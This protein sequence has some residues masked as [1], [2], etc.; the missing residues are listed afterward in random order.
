MSVFM[1]EL[2]GTAFILLFGSG[3]VAGVVLEKTKSNNSGWIVITSAWA[4]GVTMGILASGPISGAHLNPA[5]TI[6]L[7]AIGKFSWALVPKYILAQ[8]LGAMI[9]SGLVWLSY[10]D[11]FEATENQEAKLAI[12]STGP[13]I[14]NT[15]S[16]FATEFIATFILMFAILAIG[17]SKFTEGL[18]PMAVGLL[19]FGL[20]LSYGGP[21][22]Y[23]MNPARDLGPRIMHAILPFSNKGTS[24]WA[25]SWIP[26]FAPVCGAVVAAFTYTLVYV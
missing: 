24:D 23:A 3:V 20:G 5:V 10:K 13:A 1:A 19:V 7:A 16:N 21:T 18:N 2:I 26:V 17:V 4:V 11:H 12:F 9:G 15:L 6:A 22:G 8:F 25:Y 14:R